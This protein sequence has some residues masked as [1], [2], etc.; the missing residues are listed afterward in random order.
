MGAPRRGPADTG[1]GLGEAWRY[2]AICL[3]LTRR[4]LM[5]RYRRTALGAVWTVLQPTLMMIVFTVFFGLFGR[6]NNQGLPHAV[7]Y[8]LG[9]LP[10][11]VVVR[12]VTEGSNS[13]IAGSSLISR[14]YFPRVYFPV[15]T[16]LSSIVD[17]VFGCVPLVILLL[18]YR[19]VASRRT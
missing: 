3:V 7:F 11:F 5:V 15:A 16:A 17:F 13:V 4:T 19:L 12:I 14:V 1:R 9:I 18:I 10:W 2:R 6:A 8:Y